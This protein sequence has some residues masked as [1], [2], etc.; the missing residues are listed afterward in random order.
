[1]TPLR[2]RMI[3]DMQLRELSERTQETYTRAVR[4]LAE[5][6]G[7]S[8]HQL[9]EEELRQYFLFLH[10]EKRLSRASCTIVLCAIKCFYKRTLQT[11][12][13]GAADACRLGGFPALLMG[14]P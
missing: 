5:H 12:A 3:A 7:V 11:P 8:P 10:T 13:S 4:Q 1:M 2:R 9:T 6:Y 14:E